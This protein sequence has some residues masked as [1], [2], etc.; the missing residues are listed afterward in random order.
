MKLF[1]KV[2][3]ILAIFAFPVFAEPIDP[4]STTIPQYYQGPMSNLSS[5]KVDG[6][7]FPECRMPKPLHCQS[8]D[9]MDTYMW[10]RDMFIPVQPMPGAH[11]ETGESVLVIVMATEEMTGD[12]FNYL[13]FWLVLESNQE[14]MCLGGVS[15]ILLDEP[16]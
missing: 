12:L 13:E 15:G 5:C 9:V 8:V 1:T 7:G 14:E 16:A 6:D 2:F 3:S 4:N 11:P 10:A